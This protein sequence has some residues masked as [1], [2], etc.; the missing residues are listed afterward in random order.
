MQG[1]HPQPATLREGD[2]VSVNQE[3]TVHTVPIH[4]PKP[5]VTGPAVTTGVTPAAADVKP[6]PGTGTTRAPGASTGVSTRG[7]GGLTLGLI[8]L[9]LTLFLVIWKIALVALASRI[10]HHVRDRDGNLDLLR[11]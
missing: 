5:V 1:D 11:G 8:A 3:S 6:H 7:A 4:D 2:V 9:I 10:L